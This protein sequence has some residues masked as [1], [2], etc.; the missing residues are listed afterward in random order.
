[1]LK[2][3]GLAMLLTTIIYLSIGVMAISLFGPELQP[4][5]LMSL[6]STGPM[7]IIVRLIFAVVI[8]CHIPF[9]FFASKEG[10]CIV[11]DEFI[12]STLTSSFSAAVTQ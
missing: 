4:N 3:I 11:A 10:A 9:L 12:N 2:S 5:V 1:M 7:S 8:S 6:A